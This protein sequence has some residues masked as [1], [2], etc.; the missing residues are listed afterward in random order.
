MDAQGSATGFDAAL[1]A[2]E[3]LETDVAQAREGLSPSIAPVG[4]I[5]PIEAIEPIEAAA[6]IAP[7][8]VAAEP[9]AEPQGEPGSAMAEAIVPA[10]VEAAPQPVA[11]APVAAAMP[12]AAT[13]PAKKSKLPAL[14]VGL[15]LFSSVVS[16]V[17]L[18]VVSRTVVSASLVVA[19]ARERAEEMKKVGVLIHDLEAIRVRQQALLQ[20]QEAAAASPLLTAGDLDQ[21]M[22]KLDQSLAARDKSQTMMAQVNDGQNQLNATLIAIGTKVSRIEDKITAGSH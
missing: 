22:T 14:A 10:T 12:A 2:L 6:P 13:A 21:R 15:G 18:V 17:G 5:A 4:G 11:E 9:Q 8:E 19:D 16:A 3:D 7:V 20:R 1:K